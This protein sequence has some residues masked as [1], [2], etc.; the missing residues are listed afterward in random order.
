MKE[1]EYYMYII[2][3]LDTKNS[4]IVNI[5]EC[6]NT[7][8]NIDC[9]NSLV[10]TDKQIVELHDII[11]GIVTREK[12]PNDRIVND[13]MLLSLLPR[14][15]VLRVKNDESIQIKD[16]INQYCM[17]KF[18]NARWTKYITEDIVYFLSYIK[19]RTIKTKCIN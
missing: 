19:K 5:A 7:K 4:D 3:T 1:I 10:T 14:R 12:L 16:I 17:F 15:I 13:K 11:L 2:Y 18:N 6:P 9:I 8:E